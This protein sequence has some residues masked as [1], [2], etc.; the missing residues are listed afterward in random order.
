MVRHAWG[1]RPH[2][3]RN[4]STSSGW[5]AARATSRLGREDNP[6]QLEI[7]A[8]DRRRHPVQCI[9]GHP[10]PFPPGFATTSG[11]RPL[12]PVITLWWSRSKTAPTQQGR[13]HCYWGGRG[14][15][16]ASAGDLGSLIKTM[17]AGPQPRIVLHNTTKE[18]RHGSGSL[19]L[20]VRG[21]LI[22]G[23]RRADGVC[24]H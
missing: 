22:C 21:S 9:P 8:L 24:A 13:P 16:Q 7:A 20:G 14:Q 2:C 6:D 3:W 12:Y 17:L 11:N 1:P 18:S 23:F 5:R 10:N 19:I 4:S 15:H